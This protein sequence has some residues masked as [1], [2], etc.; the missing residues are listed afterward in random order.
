VVNR[1][2]YYETG[3]SLGELGIAGFKPEELN[4]ILKEGF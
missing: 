1:A 3:R 2:D 4:K